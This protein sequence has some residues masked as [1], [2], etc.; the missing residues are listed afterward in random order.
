MIESEMS[1]M[2]V[3]C[4][5]D[6]RFSAYPEK[7]FKG[8]IKA[9]SPI[10]NQEERICKVIIE[11][12]N[13]EERIKPG[14]HAEAEIAVAIHEDRLLVPQEAILIR[15]GRKLLFVV[16]DGVAKWRY[17]EIGLENGDYA[18]VLEG[19]EEQDLVI[20]DGHFTLAHDARVRI[21]Q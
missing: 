16:E 2:N 19:I 10:V 7:I 15:A 21:A 17:I 12:A 8:R 5:V 18:E 3:G 13:T 11:V 14:M 1:K 4:E 6:L 9:I 20:I